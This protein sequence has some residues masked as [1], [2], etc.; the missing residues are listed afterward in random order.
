MHHMIS[1]TFDGTWNTDLLLSFMLLCIFIIRSHH[2]ICN[3]SK[4]TE[5]LSKTHY[6]TFS[7]GFAEGKGLVLKDLKANTTEL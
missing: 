6:V 2:E 3:H 4:H 7:E 5:Q 1:G